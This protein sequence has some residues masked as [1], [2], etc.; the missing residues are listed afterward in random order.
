ML[1]EHDLIRKVCDDLYPKADSLD[2]DCRALF[3]KHV[4]PGAGPTGLL[5]DNELAFT[6][7]HLRSAA[8]FLERIGRDKGIL[9]KE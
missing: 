8:A 9:P 2:E 7:Q 4:Q 5:G 3:N 6:I 1:S